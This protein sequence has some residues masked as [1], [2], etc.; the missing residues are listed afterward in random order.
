LNQYVENAVPLD[1]TVTRELLCTI[2]HKGTPLHDGAVVIRGS[3]VAGAGCLFP[4]SENP[5]LAK[6]MGTRHRAA[7]G[8]TEECDA[9]SVVVSE[10]SG[11]I[12]V[13]VGGEIRQGMDGEKLRDLLT[14]LC[15][16]TVE[17]RE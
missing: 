14:D 6:D 12:S 10:E 9:V 13:C 1:A 5:N 8:I 4:L 17:T 7:I 11:N 16:E 3:R 15:L 2:F